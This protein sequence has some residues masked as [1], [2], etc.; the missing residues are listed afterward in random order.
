MLMIR[1]V[2]TRPTKGKQL[3]MAA[4]SRK[5]GRV[6]PQIRRGIVGILRVAADRRSVLVEA[7]LA[8][9]VG[10]MHLM[11]DSGQFREYSLLKYLH[12]KCPWSRISKTKGQ[13]LSLK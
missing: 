6:R 1:V 11:Q 2:P 8:C 10:S 9:I 7:K 4:L 13:C 12:A 3:L 5:L